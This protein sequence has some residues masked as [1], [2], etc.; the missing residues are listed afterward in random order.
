MRLSK[1]TKDDLDF[2]RSLRNASKSAFFFDQEVTAEQHQAWYQ[3]I[4]SS[5]D[6]CFWIISIG[7]IRIGTVSL[8]RHSDTAE[9]GNVLIAESM[10]HKGFARDALRMLIYPQQRFTAR[11]RPDNLASKGLFSSLGFTQVSDIDWELST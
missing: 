7:V 5:P 6:V 4:H 10:R 2:V 8:T 3:K 11:I 1:I 9:F